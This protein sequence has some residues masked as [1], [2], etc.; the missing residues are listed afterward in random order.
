VNDACVTRSL[1][2][3][4]TSADSSTWATSEKD[5]SCSCDA[6]T[7]ADGQTIYGIRQV[8]PDRLELFSLSV[9]GGTETTAGAL[10]LSHFL[11]AG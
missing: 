6:A 10:V 5:E 11:I 8:A 1:F 3:R 9:T 4:M 2:L 7:R